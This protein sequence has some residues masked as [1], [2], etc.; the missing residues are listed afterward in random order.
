MKKRRVGI[1]GGSFDPIHSGHLR[2]ARYIVESGEVDEVWLMISPL[3]PLKVGGRQLTPDA[4]RLEMARL[5][6]DGEP[7]IEVSD[8]EFSLPKP[9]YSAL[10][11]RALKEKYPNCEFRLIIGADNWQVFDR[12]RDPEFI[13]ENF[14][15]IVYPRPGYEL[16]NGSPD[17]NSPFNIQHSTFLTAAPQTDI[18]STELREMIK[19][20]DPKAADFIPP[21]TLEY[22]RQHH[23]YE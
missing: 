16:Q 11:L 12:W 18:S 8:F 9:S 19:T 1:F 4:E 5:A 6:V 13:L 3:N 17:G 22:I 7:N 10:T 15:P 21:Q 14:S 23:L 2:L 20:H